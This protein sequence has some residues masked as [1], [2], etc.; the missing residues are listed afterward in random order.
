MVSTQEENAGLTRI[1]MKK[2]IQMQTGGNT[3]S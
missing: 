2:K 3:K 1:K